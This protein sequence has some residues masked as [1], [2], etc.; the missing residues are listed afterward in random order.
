MGVKLGDIVE[1]EEIGWAE[2]KGKTIAIDAM[3]TLYQFL[4]IIRQPDGTPLMDPNGKI[5]SHLT[6]LFY[7]TIRIYENGIKPCYVFD[8]VAHAL[9]GRE[10]S[11]RK[12]RKQ[13][14][15]EKWKD[16]K[17][18]G[19]LE[20]AKKYAS[21]TS[22]FTKEMLEDAKDLIGAMGFPQVQAP[23]EGEVQAAHMCS[24]GDACA[25]GSQDFDA[26]L[27]GVPLL[28]RNMTMQE[29]FQLEK[30]RLEENLKRL[31]ITREQLV[32]VAILVGTDYNK[33]GV[34]GIG[35]KK[36]LKIVKEGKMDEYRE[37]MGDKYGIIRDLFL[38]PEVTDDYEVK[39]ASPN[40]DKIREI[41]VEEHS[42]SD[43]R[44]DRGIKRLEDAYKQNIQQS[45]LSQWF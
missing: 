24:K 26:L 39:W 14:A 34:K 22:R 28:I 38:K 15:E 25:V 20:E 10:L 18:R 19:D 6:G 7:R 13:K 31:G 3:N 30:I 11:D 42:F 43:M 40:R 1:S 35:P 44:V 36:G 37:A 32:D 45:N 41:L 16:A 12:E 17:D 2:L 8:G 27:A 5:T 23:S 33:G 9:K 29:K 4:S 21:M